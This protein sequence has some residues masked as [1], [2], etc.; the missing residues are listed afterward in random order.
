MKQVI[1]EDLQLVHAWSVA[2]KLTINPNK[3]KCTLFSTK[4]RRKK[5]IYPEIFLGSNKIDFV[6]KYE[7]LGF[8]LDNCLTFEQHLTCT[9]QRVN[10]KA[11]ILY[12]VCNL[13]NPKIALQLYKTYLLP[14][15]EYS[16]LFM[17]SCSM[18]T[19]AL[20]QKFQNRLLRLVYNPLNRISNFDLHVKANLLPVGYRRFL[21]ILRIMF[22]LS[23][24]PSRAINCDLLL[25][26]SQS[27]C[28]LCLFQKRLHLKNQLAMRVLGLGMHYL[29]T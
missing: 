28:L 21:S 12:K 24:V 19:V 6:E 8:M 14:I 15:L 23:F 11:V 10:S 9:I 25:R 17:G 18:K 3:T 4:G 29:G 26:S 16:D 22:Y 5:L 2:N 7:Y 20:L 27:Y 1:N 13:I